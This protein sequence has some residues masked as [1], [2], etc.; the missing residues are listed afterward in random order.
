MLGRFEGLSGFISLLLRGQFKFRHSRLGL[1]QVCRCFFV[2]L[3][4]QFMFLGVD[5][6]RDQNIFSI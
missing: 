6:L 1:F 4:Q 2:A 5:F 3:R